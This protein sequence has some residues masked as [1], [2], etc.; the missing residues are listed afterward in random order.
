MLSI[1]EVHIQT[2][3]Q[4][5]ENGGRRNG[6]AAS[7]PSSTITTFLPNSARALPRYSDATHA[8][9]KQAERRNLS[10]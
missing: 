10:P 1:E 5:H 8:R 7:S 2:V 4:L 9:H 6:E 3:R